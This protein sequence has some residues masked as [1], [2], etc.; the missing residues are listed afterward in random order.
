MRSMLF[1]LASCTAS[2]SSSSGRLWY[3]NG[4]CTSGNGQ[5]QNF[6][7]FQTYVGHLRSMHHLESSSSLA[8]AINT[9]QHNRLYGNPSVY[10]CP[11]ADCNQVCIEYV[12]IKAHWGLRHF[13]DRSPFR[14]LKVDIPSWLAID[15][16]H[17]R[18]T[19]KT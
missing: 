3:C 1:L 5:V 11:H 8:S 9:C 13:D 4:T 12:G 10:G 2:K 18:L 7:N 19:M 17:A 16:S 15:N 14:F 6:K